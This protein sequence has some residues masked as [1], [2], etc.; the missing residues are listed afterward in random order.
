MLWFAAGCLVGTLT[1]AQDSA[2]GRPVAIEVNADRA[3]AGLRMVLSHS[4]SVE[5]DVSGGEGRIDIVYS[6]PI[7][8]T[9]SSRTYRSGAVQR[10]AISGSNTLTLFTTAEY[11]KHEAYELRNP[12]R[13]VVDVSGKQDTGSI[14]TQPSTRPSGTIVVLDPGH[15]GHE[16]GAVGPSGLEEKEVA[17]DLARRLKRKLQQ[18]TSI[19]VVLTRD[20]DRIMG[21]DERTATANHN[22][23]DLFVSIHLNSSPRTSARGAETYFVSMSAT[24]DEARTLA[25]LENRASGVAESS[26]HSS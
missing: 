6:A 21:L 22:R 24:D 18:E 26:I 9:P 1:M 8:V 15:G 5:Y 20:E 3:G 10:Y 7:R 2:G 11:G 13:L 4:R 17:L 25:A 23:A 14:T 19:N 16:R 12:F